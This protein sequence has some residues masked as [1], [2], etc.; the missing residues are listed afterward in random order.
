MNLGDIQPKGVQVTIRRRG[1][2]LLVLLNPN[3]A[4]LSE[5]IW[6]KNAAKPRVLPFRGIFGITYYVGS[7]INTFISSTGLC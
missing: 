1:E 6:M 2:L 3:K 5:S 4:V 7:D